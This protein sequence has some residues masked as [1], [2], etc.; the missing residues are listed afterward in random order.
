MVG[1]PRNGRSNVSYVCADERA[2][3]RMD[4]RARRARRTTEAQPNS[5]REEPSPG[6]ETP[7]ERTVRSTFAMTEPIAD[8]FT[9]HTAP[10]PD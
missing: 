2:R 5:A 1:G 9:K 7:S 3:S 10:R 8:A 4:N 6:D